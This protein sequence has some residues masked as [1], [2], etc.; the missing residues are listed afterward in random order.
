MRRRALAATCLSHG[1]CG[2]SYTG[3]LQID[4]TEIS[5]NVMFKVLSFRG[6]PNSCV[7]SH[8][9][10]FYCCWPIRA[11]INPSIWHPYKPLDIQAKHISPQAL[12]RFKPGGWLRSF[13]V[14]FLGPPF[15]C[16]PALQELAPFLGAGKL[17]GSVLYG[18][19]SQIGLN[20]PHV[21]AMSSEPLQLQIPTDTKKNNDINISCA[22][23]CAFLRLPGKQHYKFTTTY[24]NHTFV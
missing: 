21:L 19:A 7:F 1:V 20:V 14:V 23:P 18:V 12:R 24:S 16:S 13:N 11:Q 22:R 6:S 17:V 3:P 8:S 9:A 5:C 2:S 10:W 15:S 4:E